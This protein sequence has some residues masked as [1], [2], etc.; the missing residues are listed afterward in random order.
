M[1]ERRHGFRRWFCRKFCWD[2]PAVDKP[3]EAPKELRDASH[4]LANAVSGLQ[5]AAN[6]VIRKGDAYH[7]MAR[8]LR[9]GKDG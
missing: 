2:T 3:V 1:N 8:A 6:E 7:A 9:G 4:E 5:G